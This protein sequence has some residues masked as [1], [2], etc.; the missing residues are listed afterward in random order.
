MNIS[1]SSHDDE[2]Q[3]VQD[4]SNYWVKTGIMNVVDIGLAEILVA[5]LPSQKVPDKQQ[6]ESDQTG[7]TSPVD[8]WVTEKVVFHNTIVPGAHAQTDVENR[9]L[10]EFGGQ[11]VLLV[12]VGDQGIV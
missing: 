7:G 11:V 8:E 2:W 3:I 9:P 4:P 12:G 6:A 1:H 5:A 10:P